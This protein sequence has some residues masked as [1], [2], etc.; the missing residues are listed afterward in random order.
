MTKTTK[1]ALGILI[2]AVLLVV[3][4]YGIRK[5]SISISSE[6]KPIKIGAVLSLTGK[7]AFVGVE[8]K[9]GIE[10]GV[11]ELKPKTIGGRRIEIIYEDTKSQSNE[12]VNAVKKLI[13]IDGVN[14]I[15]G[16]VRSSSVLAAAPVAEARKVI[17][18]S[19]I[20]TAEDITLAGDYVFRNRETG[21]LHAKKMAEFLIHKGFKKVAVF[22]AQS[23]NAITYGRLFRENF[24]DMGGKIMHS[25]EYNEDNIDFKTD[26][27]M[28]VAND[29]EAF[30]LA[31]TSGRDAG[32]ITQQIVELGFEGLITGPVLFETEEYLNM[33]G[34][35]SE[36][37]L[38]TAPAFDI[39]DSSI[40][41]YRERFKTLHGKES[42]FMAANGYD[43]LQIILKAI[44]FC[45]GDTNTDCVRDFL[46]DLKDY[47]GI[48]GNTTFDENGDVIKPVII[49]TIKDGQFVKYSN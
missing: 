24:L 13:E 11:N 29:A 48:G 38:Y 43:A 4:W 10:L 20:A 23:A 9:N 22:T 30:Y 46:Y 8:V 42:N 41:P 1:I 14:I 19:P 25:A 49:K 44:S 16:P 7:V 31:S 2:I 45:G 33:A 18:F 39:K 27:S 3:V 28:A 26:I 17:L 21:V 15:I 35:A 40:Q 47:P 5:E 36:G 34:D 12:A 37:V 32:I 6:E